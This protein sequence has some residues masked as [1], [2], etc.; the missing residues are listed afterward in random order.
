MGAC[1]EKGEGGKPVS[2][3]TKLITAG[4]LM[5]YF[6]RHPRVHEVSVPAGF[7]YV[8]ESKYAICPALLLASA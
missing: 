3:F 1:D 7:F 8:L 6:S 5:H 4:E 2:K